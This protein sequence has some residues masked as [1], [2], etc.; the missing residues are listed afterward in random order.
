[1]DLSPGTGRAPL[2]M[3]VFRQAVHELRLMARRPEWLALGN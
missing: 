2:D 3:I 1:M